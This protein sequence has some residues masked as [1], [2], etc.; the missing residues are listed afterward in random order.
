MTPTND[1]PRNHHM[2]ALH[3]SRDN[4]WQYHWFDPD[5]FTLP[6][7][8]KPGSQA[9]TTTDAGIGTIAMIATTS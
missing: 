4:Q 8:S 5:H 7:I 6:T 2:E 9:V 1:T 3:P